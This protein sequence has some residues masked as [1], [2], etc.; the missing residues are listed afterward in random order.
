MP[1]KN[2][3]PPETQSG[4]PQ[5][6]EALLNRFSR[7]EGQVGGLKEM[8]EDDAYCIDLINQIHSVEKALQGAAAEI[9]DNHLRNCV[10]EAVNSDNPYEEQ[11][12]LQEFMETVTKFL[13]Q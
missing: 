2:D 11:E 8:V 12:K 6:R 3:S 4:S 9:M 1:D 5:D 13:K 7:I 10:S